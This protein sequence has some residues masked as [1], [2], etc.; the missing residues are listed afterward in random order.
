[1]WENFKDVLEGGILTLIY[2]L[3]FSLLTNDQ[4]PIMSLEV[5]LI[6]LLSVAVI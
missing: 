2:S 6:Y 3:K 4:N 5:I 1:M